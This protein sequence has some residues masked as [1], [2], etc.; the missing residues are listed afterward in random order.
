M[1]SLQINC[2]RD[3]LDIGDIAPD[4][5]IRNQ[6]NKEVR[7]SNYKGK[8]IILVFYGR[9]DNNSTNEHLTNIESDY[10]KYIEFCAAVI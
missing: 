3:T 9:T 5:N 1:A 7:L 2:S 6:E 10:S 8:F 4:F